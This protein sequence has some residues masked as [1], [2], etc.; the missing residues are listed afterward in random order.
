MR[1]HQGKL[2]R[3]A[4]PGSAPGSLRRLRKKSSATTAVG[5]MVLKQWSRGARSWPARVT[6]NDPRRARRF[7]SSRRRCKPSRLCSSTSHAPSAESRCCKRDGSV[8]RVYRLLGL[9]EVQVREAGPA[10]RALPEVMVATVA[11]R[12]NQVAAIPSTVARTV[13]QVR[14][15]IERQ[16]LVN[17]TCPKCDSAYLVE[18]W[19]HDK[20][21]YLVCPNNREFLPKRSR[22]RV[23]PLRSRRLR[24]A[25]T[26]RR[27][28]HRRLKKRSLS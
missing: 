19:Q 22:R 23:N 6:T 2:C 1:L 15:H 5:V 7:A 4:G 9:S 11:V 26:R 20:G 8:W 10:R 12:K 24:S 14:F 3:Q 17:Q 16:K 28:V 18:L 21:T 25:C 13:S 27:L